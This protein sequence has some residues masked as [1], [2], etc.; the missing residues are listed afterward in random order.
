MNERII[1]GS[2]TGEAEHV[3]GVAHSMMI[4]LKSEVNL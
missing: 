3:S 2:D 1:D 4:R